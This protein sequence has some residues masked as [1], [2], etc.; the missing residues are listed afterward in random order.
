M[1][2]EAMSQDRKKNGES[3]RTKYWT[4]PKF[5]DADQTIL[6]HGRALFDL[7]AKH[8]MDAFRAFLIATGIMVSVFAAMWNE[9]AY[10]ACF[11]ISAAYLVIN[12]AFYALDQRVLQLLHLAEDM[13]KVAEAKLAN[14]AKW[15]D[16]DRE[17]VEFFQKSETEFDYLKIAGQTIPMFP[18]TY[19]Y[20]F[21]SLFSLMSFL[22]IIALTFSAIF[23][24]GATTAS[25]Q[26]SD[27]VSKYWVTQ[28]AISDDATR[29]FRDLTG[30]LN[31]E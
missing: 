28:P 12:L 2:A 3:L 11:I 1:D 27:I 9:G 6:E 19:R 26:S 8:R 7:H 15:Y 21:N 5:D 24:I 18:V 13:I 30:K 4:E 17:K 31:S 22:S 23:A 16:S 14:T 10:S 25:R 20:V 29:R